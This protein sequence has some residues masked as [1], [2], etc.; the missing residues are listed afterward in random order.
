MSKKKIFRNFLLCILVSILPVSCDIQK[1]I[2]RPGYFVQKKSSLPDKYF[3][4]D[5]YVSMHMPVNNSNDSPQ[6]SFEKNV[7]AETKQLHADKVITDVQNNKAQTPPAKVT[8]LQ[9]SEVKREESNRI[10]PI[11][12]DNAVISEPDK[13]KDYEDLILAFLAGAGFVLAVSAARKGIRKYKTV[14]A[15]KKNQQEIAN[16][17]DR[18]DRCADR[19]A[20]A[21]NEKV[22]LAARNVSAAIAKCNDIEK[23]KKL[24]RSFNEVYL[25]P[26]QSSDLQ[27]ITLNN[28]LSNDDGYGGGN[29]TLKPDVVTTTGGFYSNSAGSISWTMGEPISETV[30]DGNDTLTQGFQ[31]GAYSIVSVSEVDAPDVNITVY[32]NPFVSTLNIKSDGNDPI[33]IEAID[34]Q[35]NVI[36]D[37][38]FEN[39][40]GQMDLGNLPEAIYL[41]RVYDNNGKQLKVFKIQKVE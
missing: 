21:K 6:V 13:K 33:R 15:D 31:Q 8:E 7:P 18:L 34:L 23:A 14:E 40:Q 26:R 32:P 41:L 16:M 17:A 29:G 28:L 19:F 38:S 24:E 30:T 4:P 20:N 3:L 37:Q 22:E 27:F 11:N 2:Y 25:S 9:P 1:R 10:V 5:K 39:G 35:G 36:S 12:R